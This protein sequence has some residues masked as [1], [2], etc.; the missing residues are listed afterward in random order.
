MNR[1]EKLKGKL[2]G[3]IHDAYAM[4]NQIVEVLQKQVDRAKDVP[5]IQAKIQQ[6]LDQTKQHRA[7]MEQCLQTYGEQPSAMKGAMSSL[8][9]NMAGMMSGARADTLAKD[10]RDDYVTEHLEIVAYIM[11]MTTANAYGDQ[12]TMQAAAA[13]LRDE[14]EMQRWLAQHAPEATLLSLQQGGITVPDSAWQFARQS[15]GELHPAEALIGMD[16]AAKGMGAKETFGA[17]ATS[18]PVNAGD[19]MTLTE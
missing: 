3:Y 16:L 13:N 8:M 11:L 14:V 4:E 15:Q 1:D 10:A 18:A 19:G 6:H 7:R 17:G 2:V 5:Q 9:G 12:Q